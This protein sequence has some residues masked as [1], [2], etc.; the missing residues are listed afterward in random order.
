MFS[1]LKLQLIVAFLFILLLSLGQQFVS[2]E[3]QKLLTSGLSTTQLVA[4]KVILVKTLEKD[5]LDLQRSVLL[6]Q[7]NNSESV[8]KRFN[9]IMIKVNE[10]LGVIKA[11]ISESHIDKNQSIAIVS[12]QEHLD[13]YQNNF[14][15]VVA[16]LL[17]RNELFNTKIIINFE[18]LKSALVDSLK[19][20]P[21]DSIQN[22]QYEKLLASINQLQIIV[23]EYALNSTYEPIEKFNT[24][25]Q[26]ITE[27]LA[28]INVSGLTEKVDD[29]AK[30]FAKLT[31][32]TR[33]YQYLVN[34]VMSGSANEFLYLA[35]KL[36]DV[37]FAHL[38][39]TNNS[40]NR[41]VEQSAFRS[42][43]M[44]IIG[45]FLLFSV[46]LFVVVR[47]IFPI[48][49]V[50]KV[51]DVLAS[52]KELD[53]ELAV[54]RIDEIG[55]LMQSANIF[56]NKNIQTNTLL[57][58]SQKL[59]EQLVIETE[60]AEHATKAKSMFLANMSHEI[61]TPLNGIVGLVE[62]LSVKKL[63][64]QER[65]YITKIRY[66][67][68]IL[69]SV[70]NDILDF[71]KIEAGKLEIETLIF[72]PVTVFE[73]AIEVVTVKSAEKNIN[74]YC[75]IPHDFPVS[76]KGDPVRLSQI[77]LNLL[78]N[79][80]KFTK[81][82]QVSLNITWQEGIDKNTIDIVADIIDTGIGISAEQQKNIFDDFE[83]ADGTTSR[84][85]GGT[86]LGLSISKQL[87]QLMSGDILLNSVLGEGSQFSIVLPFGYDPTDVSLLN[88]LRKRGELYLCQLGDTSSPEM[89]IS[90]YVKKLIIVEE[91]TL[92]AES[93]FWAQGSAL[94]INSKGAFTAKHEVMIKCLI[95]KGVNIGVSVDTHDLAT[96]EKL[97][98]IGVKHII[99][100]PLLPTKLQS[101]I[102]D[103][104]SP[105]T[106]FSVEKEETINIIDDTPQFTGHVL[107]V[108]DNKINQ[109]VAGKALKNFGLTFELAEDGEQAFQKVIN[110]VK[111]RTAYDLVFM[112]IQMPI[113]DG[114]QA[115]QK[116]REYGINDLVI[117]GLS[118]NAMRS[119]IEMGVASGMNEYI[120][121]PLNKKDMQ[122]ILEKHLVIKIS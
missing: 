66:S 9:G 17:K 31:Q 2:F 1:S 18:I 87:A 47:L 94:F 23:Y 13:S 116:I 45:L 115:T 102:T 3:S 57:L 14:E 55:Q 84:H 62:L 113:L 5:V 122:N 54:D 105:V 120:T 7:E 38:E 19:E 69:M 10:K 118:A 114:Y 26:E 97:N 27:N 95:D 44:F 41:T 51:F 63:P 70:I 67:T 106:F 68:N 96:A 42:N 119:D 90:N 99:H 72:N 93:N 30:D 107:L 64:A 28:V 59:N 103:L 98:E 75:D 24:R 78:N 101:F 100:H 36:S 85:Y 74:I 56:Q 65:E 43:T 81:E 21:A 50:T 91:N 76:L 20:F 46:V 53:E 73:N 8:L 35:K 77:L 25:Y 12:M 110:K 33:N 82:G 49:K 117:C 88:N 92:V 16:V 108:E 121:K 61:R 48:Q 15:V 79:A 71:S 29:I 40:L 109:L 4:K 37:V 58:Q 34:V 32:V 60:K 22:Q 80:V 89:I 52:N 11:F 83:Q 104:V 111:E 112:D 39:L 86:G 6:Y